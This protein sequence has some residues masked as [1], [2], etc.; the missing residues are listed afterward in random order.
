MIVTLDQYYDTNFYN[1]C[2]QA[3]KN[4]GVEFKEYISTKAPYQFYIDVDVQPAFV[5]Y[6]EVSQSYGRHLVNVIRPL[7]PQSDYVYLRRDSYSGPKALQQYG[8]NDALRSAQETKEGI[9]F[10]ATRE[11]ILRIS[12]EYPRK[13][14]FMGR[15][16]NRRYV[17]FFADSLLIKNY[18]NSENILVEGSGFGDVTDL[19]TELN[20]RVFHLKD[21]LMKLSETPY[22]Q[23]GKFHPIS[24]TRPDI[25]DTY[26][27]T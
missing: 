25:T 13:I 26:V 18:L 11:S 15:Y 14:W 24:S 17:V 3:L 9:F 22:V 4:N 10:T 23:G 20:Y 12:K 8:I 21:R 2:L 16:F 19:E 6:D 27:L 1:E 7:T 5:N